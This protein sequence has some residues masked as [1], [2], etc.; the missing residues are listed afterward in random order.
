[1]TPPTSRRL[2]LRT[3]AWSVPAITVAAAAPA[4]ASSPGAS[5]ASQ[6]SVSF[7]KSTTDPDESGRITVAN[8]SSEDLV[9]D[10]SFSPVPDEDTPYSLMSYS[11]FEGFTQVSSAA[12]FVLTGTIR[13]GQSTSGW[14]WWRDN[15]AVRG[16]TTVTATISGPDGD[17]TPA[18]AR[19]EIV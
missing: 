17:A 19:I 12:G 11:G 13:A 1:M 15:G 14:C 10:L 16:V 2:L 9:V 5:A 8:P 3:A 4:F 6:A 18:P 7:E